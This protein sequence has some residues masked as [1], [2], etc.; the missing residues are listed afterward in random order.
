M[1]ESPHFPLTKVIFEAIEY[2]M[3]LPT[4]RKPKINVAFY[5][6][7]ELIPDSSELNCNKKLSFIL[8]DIML[9]KKQTTAEN[10]FLLMEDIIT[11]AVFT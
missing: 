11:V 9:E 3:K 4:K 7:F 10:F 5:E 1:A 8:D 6:N 2:I